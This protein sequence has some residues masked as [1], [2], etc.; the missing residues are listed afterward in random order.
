MDRPDTP[1][2]R[3][4]ALDITAAGLAALLA[5]TAVPAALVF[6]V[7]NPLSDGLGHT[8]HPLP[9]DA[10]CVLAVAAWVAWVAC[11]AQLARSVLAHV[12]NGDTDAPRGGTVMD[13]L[14]A[15][16]AVG[17]LALTTI[18]PPVALSSSAG[19]SPP[20]TMHVA[21]RGTP[22]TQRSSPGVHTLATTTHAVQPGDTLWSIADDDMAD[23]ADW[24]AIAALNLGR[25]MADGTRFVDPDHIR[26][27][28][29]LRVPLAAAAPER[30]ASGHSRTGGSA[31]SDEHLPELIALG[32]GSIACA[33]LARRARR[34]R[35]DPFTGE[36][37]L[38]RS[39]SEEAVDAAALLHRFDG[40][41]AL[42]SF[43]VANRLLGWSL[44][45]EPAGA[46][47]RAICVSPSGVTFWLREPRTDAPHGFVALADG[48]AW[49]VAH[50][51]VPDYVAHSPHVPLALPVGDDV[52]G[53]WLVG[54]G[55]GDVL[56]LLGESAPSLLR[57]ARSAVSAWD[58]SDMILVTDEPEDPGLR[59]P[60][61]SG[62]PYRL[63]FGDP[64]SL[65]P[66]AAPHAAVVTTATVA[67]SDLTVLVDRQG[68]TLHPMARVVRPWLQSA[69]AGRRIEEL[70][71]PAAEPDLDPG[72]PAV[73]VVTAAMPEDSR[74]TSALAPGAVDVRLLTM[75]PRLEGLHEDLP[76]NR[77]RRAVELVAYLA[78]HQPDVITGD[79]LRTRVLGSSDSDAASKTLF[80]TA[81]AA[82]R[83][84]GVDEL[85]EPLFPAGSRNGLYQVS[86]RV[87]VDVRRAMALAARGASVDD[88]ALAIAHYRAALELVEGEPLANAL[89]GYSWW[90]AEGHGGRI[91]T[92]L[93]DAACSMATLASEGGHFELAHWGLERARL[94]EPYSETLSRAAMQLAAAE[95]DADRLRL[96]WRECLRMVDA[97]DPG[98][99]PSLRTESLYGELSR[100]VLVDSGRPRAE[101]AR[102]AP[103]AS[104]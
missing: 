102:Y 31:H 95:G 67:A 100:R 82:R 72:S 35:V 22:L 46:V 49:H 40:V 21:G 20:P 23:G 55:S 74:G 7:G 2:F 15:R 24:T 4:R 70:T 63:F 37:D 44:R 91:A 85:G 81:H 18:G 62:A 14:A 8:W 87:T 32:L 10:L 6:V 5:F 39:P 57:A 98:S 86:P 47:A 69:E 79:R 36:L 25:D 101:R 71:A 56:P 60:A 54:L 52:E 59:S 33:A 97:L 34:H 50:G 16:I 3:Q 92:V 77:A 80:N 75:S 48:M 73:T 42:H 17:V 27:G 64:R 1:R 9:R 99:T 30:A 13:R 93:V 51:A 103:A 28:W 41:P 104:D 68:A 61:G 11:C 26:P 43:E 88:P 58:W 65:P 76:P 84:M 38:E 96:E 90:E 12:R 94:L 78:L 66:E 19:A 29:Q 53:T 89:S 83:A 45:D